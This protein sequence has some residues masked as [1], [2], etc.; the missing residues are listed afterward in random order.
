MVAALGGGVYFIVIVV[1]LASALRQSNHLSGGIF[2]NRV[3]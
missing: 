3:S 1:R 2:K